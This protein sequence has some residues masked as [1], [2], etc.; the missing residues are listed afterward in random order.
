MHN[1]TE[2]QLSLTGD[3]NNNGMHSKR[4]IESPSKSDTNDGYFF[5]TEIDRE[6]GIRTKLFDNGNRTKTVSLFDGKTAVVRELT[7][8]DTKSISRYQ[9][10]DQ[11]R[12]MI[13]AVAVA[14]T[15]DGKAEIFEY[16]EGMKLKSLNKLIAM[17]QD[18]N[19]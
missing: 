12:Y 16:F 13:A 3:P 6:L 17:F 8:R 15:I 2:M 19:F 5:E 1:E 9:G 14:T 10:Q 18:L 11:E 4:P 7:G